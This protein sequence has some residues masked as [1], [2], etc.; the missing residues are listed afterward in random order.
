MGSRSR[1]RR[2]DAF[3]QPLPSEPKVRGE[4]RN[5]QIRATL[6]PLQTGERPT[7]IKVAVVVAILLGLTN[8]VLLA[9]GY[10]VPGRQETNAAGAIGFSLLMFFAAGGMWARRY[11]AVL[12]FQCLLALACIVAAVSLLVASNVQAVLL[13]LALMVSSGTLFWFLIRAM[14]R[15][16]MPERPGSVRRH[17]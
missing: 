1:K 11:W 10:D 12:G 9:T 8:L 4:A 15:I 2:R 16:Q 5:E 7:A 17:G 13:C 3:G 6:E 14:A